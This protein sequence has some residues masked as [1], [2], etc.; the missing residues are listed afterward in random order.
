MEIRIEQGK[1]EE[2]EKIRMIK[3]NGTKQGGRKSKSNAII[4]QKKK[5]GKNG[6]KGREWNR[7]GASCF[8]GGAQ[9]FYAEIFGA[10]SS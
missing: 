1:K 8:N 5:G 7:L 3:R 10:T 9:C 2:R 6:E 4:N